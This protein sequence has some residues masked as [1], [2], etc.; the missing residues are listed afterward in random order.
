MYLL[1]KIKAIINRVVSV[2]EI[3]LWVEVT[4]LKSS[5]TSKLDWLNILILLKVPNHQNTFKCCSKT[6]FKCLKNA[7]M[8]KKVEASY[9]TLWKPVLDGQKDIEKLWF[10]LKMVHIEQLMTHTNSLNTKAFFFS[11]FCSVTGCSWQLRFD[12]PDII[13]RCN[14]FESW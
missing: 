4:L 14:K 2:M 5:V 13:I 12:K 6:W 1:K 7:T 8:K 10:Y 11:S 3:V 9:I